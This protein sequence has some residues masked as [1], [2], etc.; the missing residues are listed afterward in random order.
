[1][2]SEVSASVQRI[3]NGIYDLQKETGIFFSVHGPVDPFLLMCVLKT[4]VTKSAGGFG[5]DS[6]FDN[7]AEELK[8][9]V[10]LMKKEDIEAILSYVDKSTGLEE[11]TLEEL[12]TTSISGFDR[13]ANKNRSFNAGIPFYELD[14]GQYADDAFESALKLSF[15]DSFGDT[16]SIN[17]TV[18]ELAADILDVKENEFFCDFMCG[19]CLSSAIILNGRHNRG[20]SL[21]DM[22]SVA[23]GY[24]KVFSFLTGRENSGRMI[25]AFDK[26]NYDDGVKADKIFVNPPLRAKLHPFDYEGISIKEASVAAVLKAC[27]ALNEHGRAFAVLNTGFLFGSQF[28]LGA[29]RKYLIDND[30][31]EAVV[32]LPSLW[33]YTNIPTVVLILSRERKENIQMIDYSGKA[34]NSE[35]FYY[36]SSIES[37]VLSRKAV[38]DITE[39]IR[40]KKT[41]EDESVFVSKERIAGTQNYNL[42][43][44]V[45]VSVKKEEFRTLEEVDRDIDN[46]ISELKKL[47]FEL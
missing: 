22:H 6:A 35:Y 1:M 27:G 24:A 45:Y 10:P 11:R 42:L 44:S 43:P 33:K 36:D 18:A 16:L 40:E 26:D 19:T 29:V 7:I 17:Y 34:G 20:V 3:F 28:S 14:L 46:S 38:K 31:V 39:I 2:K 9:D 13:I 23:Y 5:R 32:L 21:S 8:K 37:G 4:A 12:F 25:D 30:F 15:K 41:I 47:F